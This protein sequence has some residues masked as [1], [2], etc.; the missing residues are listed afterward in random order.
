MSRAEKRSLELPYGSFDILTFSPIKNGIAPIGVEGKYIPPAI[1]QEIRYRRNTL[2]V[3]VRCGGTI[4]FYAETKPLAVR[5]DSENIPFTFRNHLVRVK[6]R[7]KEA[8]TL[9]LR[10]R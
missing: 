6:V 10:T 9:T 2:E 8:F 5:K 4:L 3:K 1:F 7:S